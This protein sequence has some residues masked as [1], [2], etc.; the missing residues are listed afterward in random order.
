MPARY[1]GQAQNTSSGQLQA[2]LPHLFFRIPAHRDDTF[3]GQ[4]PSSRA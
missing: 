4:Q 2:Q 1:S 3:S